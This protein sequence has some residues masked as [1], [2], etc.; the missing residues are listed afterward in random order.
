MN[1]YVAQVYRLGCW[2]EPSNADPS[3]P[4]I[5]GPDQATVDA[6]EPHLRAHRE[7][8]RLGPWMEPAAVAVWASGAWREA[9]K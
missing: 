1:S 5:S 2:I 9:D 6:A 8:H 7:D 3:R 4:A